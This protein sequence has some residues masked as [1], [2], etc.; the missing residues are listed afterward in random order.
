[1]AASLRNFFITFILSLLLFAGLAYAYYGDLVSVLPLPGNG[2]NASEGDMSGETSDGSD[3]PHTSDTSSRPNTVDPGDEGDGLGAINGLIVTK[4][5]KG[6]VFSAQFLRINS[7]NRRIIT[8]DLS[9][10]AELYNDLGAQVPLSDYLR[11]YE[12]DQKAMHAICA[13]TGYAADFYLV[14]TP[15]TVKSMV[16]NLEGVSLPLR[17]ACCY[18]NPIYDGRTFEEDE[19][20]PQDYYLWID[21]GTDLFSEDTLSEI[22]GPY[23]A[24]YDKKNQ[25]PEGD[26]QGQNPD[27]I[28]QE[29]Y[30]YLLKQLSGGNKA[31]LKADTDRL[32]R[33]LSGGETN[34]TPMYLADKAE[35]LFKYGEDNYSLVS[36]PY[37]SR[38]ATL[39]SIK[40][41]DR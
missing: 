8:C 1:M 7:K 27:A 4:N 29:V 33:A 39:R 12:V 2:S 26:V 17:Q 16:A 6:E 38:D 21:A 25:Y 23:A 34:L 35:L 18:P 10:K 3:G 11:L 22:L 40:Q 19:L 36:V 30:S 13:L 9:L 20:L 41:E 31:L 32:A 14:V 5:A 24:A 28:L 37:T 15:D